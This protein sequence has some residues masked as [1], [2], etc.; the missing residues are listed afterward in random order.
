REA[1]VRNLER[2]V[3]EIARKAA[4]RIAR[5]ETAVAVTTDNLEEFVGHPKIPIDA[6]ERIDRSGVATGL[7]WTPAGGDILF[8]EAT[9]TP[10]RSGRLLITGSLGDVMRESAQAALTWVRAHGELTGVTPQ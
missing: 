8:I 2:K 4:L 10:A 3:A 9:A 1:G 7:A 5:G 6:A